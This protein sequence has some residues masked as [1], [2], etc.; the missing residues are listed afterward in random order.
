MPQL[1]MPAVIN[2]Y[3][4]NECMRLAMEELLYTNGVDIIFNGH[5]HEYEMSN[6]VYVRLCYLLL[7]HAVQLLPRP[8][9]LLQCC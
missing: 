1:C 3:K 8:F 2:H 5:C 7:Q 6:P 9:K 4:E